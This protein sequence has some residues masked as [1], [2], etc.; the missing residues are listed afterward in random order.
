[1]KR[2]YFLISALAILLLASCSKELSLEQQQPPEIKPVDTLQIPVDTI[3]AGPD[4]TTY[5]ITG[6]YQLK[7]FYSDIPIDYID[8]DSVVKHETELWGYVSEYL[9]D[10]VN[11]FIENTTSV[12]IH[13]NAI[14]ME[15]MNDAVLHMKYVIGKDDKGAYFKFLDNEYKPLKYRLSVIG[16]NYF[17]IYLPWK[18]GSTIYSRF[19]RVF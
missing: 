13:Q 17:I 15:G 8:N 19:E 1:M 11:D 12:E 6:K 10:D 16:K 3:P 5:F 2:T 18:N 14:K 4:T 7:N 9:K